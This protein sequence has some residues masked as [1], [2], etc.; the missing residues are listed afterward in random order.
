MPISFFEG[1]PEDQRAEV[2]RRNMERRFY[3]LAAAVRDHEASARRTTP[4]SKPRDER[5]YLFPGDSP[6]GYRLP[7]DS[8]PWV[9][10]AWI[11][12]AGGV[13]WMRAC[14]R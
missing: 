6:M 12:W 7:I 8:L 3:A 1:I 5:L 13:A 2:T 4:V 11:A 9:A 10:A 14:R